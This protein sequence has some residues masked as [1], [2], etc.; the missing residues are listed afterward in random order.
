MG[1]VTIEDSCNGCAACTRVCPSVALRSR[2]HDQSIS[3]FHLP[4]RC[5]GCGACAATCPL[6]SITLDRTFDADLLE[7]DDEVSVFSLSKHVCV[8]CGVQLAPADSESRAC[9]PCR[10]RY[11]EL[12]IKSLVRRHDAEERAKER[13]KES[14][15]TQASPTRAAY[16]SAHGG[17]RRSGDRVR[18]ETPA[19][20]GLEKEAEDDS[21]H[22]RS[23]RS[24]LRGVPPS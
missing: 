2:A 21:S 24:D 23:R 20:S 1:Q 5:T 12:H 4:S 16:G 18:G 14:K 8:A 15:D 9:A 13:D 11:S 3:L 6:G 22:R 7:R 10:R 17:L 19:P